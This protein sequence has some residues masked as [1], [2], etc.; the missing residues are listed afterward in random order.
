MLRI[1]LPKGSLESATLQLF[2]DADLEVVR[3]SNVDY[4]ATIDDPRVNEVYILRPQEIARY[5]ADGMF[6][7]GITG[8]DWIEESGAEVETIATL[9]YSKATTRPIQVVLAVANDA[10]WATAGELPDGLRVQT[11]YPELTA[12]YFERIGVRAELSLSYG[13]TEAKVPEIADAVVE[14]TE[15]GRALKAANLRI[16]D[17]LLVSQTELIANPASAA[18]PEK[19]RA[20]DQ[21]Q[22]LLLGV[23]DARGRVLV[24]CN[25]EAAQLDA[26]LALL[27][28]LK[29]PTVSELSGGAAFA[30][31]SVAA[32]REINTLIPAL[33]EA[34]ASGILEIPIAKIVP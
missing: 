30:V 34:G 15:T 1:V 6:D 5:V 25:V 7:L 22:T 20:M 28:A 17:T 10:P 16:L 31:E 29:A 18:D 14:I 27:P 8:R 2:A 3:G 24:K 9:S 19:R 32:K 21:L 23:L 4:R 13:A 12:R 33:K 26:V 11:E